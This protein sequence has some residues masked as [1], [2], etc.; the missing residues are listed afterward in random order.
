[1]NRN[2]VHHAENGAVDADAQRETDDGE[3]GK[4]GVLNQGAGGVAQVL[5]ERIHS[6]IRRRNPKQ[7]RKGQQKNKVDIGP[8]PTISTLFGGPLESAPE[9]VMPRMHIVGLFRAAAIFV[10]A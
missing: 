4:P 6:S 3:R 2:R 1:P 9:D 10:A 7:V 8:P 5:E